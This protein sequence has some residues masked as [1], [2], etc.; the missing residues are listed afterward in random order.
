MRTVAVVIALGSLI[1]GLPVTQSAGAPAAA[2]RLGA[3]VPLTGR[4]ANGGAQVKAGYE[5]AV[6]DINARGGLQVGNRRVPL[7]VTILDDESDPTKT[8]SRLEALSTQ[9]VVALLGG[10]GSDLHAAAAAVAEKNRIPYCGVAFALHAIHERGFRFLFSPFPKSPELASETYR[11]LNASLPADQ[12]PRRVAIFRERTDWGRE[13][14]DIWTARSRENGYQVVLVGDY[15][16]L[17]RDL[18][19]LILRAKNAGAEAVF[20]VPTPPDGITLIRQMKEL[21]FNP[22][23]VIMIRAADA[24]SWAQALGKDG[25]AVLLAPGWHHALRFPGVEALNA[26]HE[27]R[28]G[29]PADV[30]VGPA[31]ACV[32]I[33][34]DAIERA[35]KLDPGAI[36]D[37]MATTSLQTVIGPVRF[38]PDGTGI[39][40]TVFVQWQAGKQELVWPKDLGAGRFVYPAPRW[41]DR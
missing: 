29:R 32:Q 36:R 35:G 5:F 39:V 26:K 22:K 23:V 20:S 27:R 4:Y 37:A 8:V 28:F 19:D 3:V 18:S 12:R 33:A 25:D 7:E 9:G 6:E 17:S 1:F 10:F 40:P 21:D 14:G 24:A 30:I 31:Y 13:L 2:V 34:A 15:T 38:R 11:F 41:R 16:P